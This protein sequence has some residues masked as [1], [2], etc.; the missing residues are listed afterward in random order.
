M[1]P[2]KN[3]NN[4]DKHTL[5]DGHVTPFFSKTGYNQSKWH[6]TWSLIMDLLQKQVR[7]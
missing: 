2:M 1:I 6:Q 7:I 3:D 5:L 4:V